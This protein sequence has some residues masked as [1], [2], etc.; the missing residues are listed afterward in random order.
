MSISFVK[1]MC[2]ISS[3]HIMPGSLSARSFGSKNQSQKLNINNIDKYTIVMYNDGQ[4]YKRSINK[5]HKQISKSV[6]L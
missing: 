5:N 6:S 1:F 3:S 2:D 4:W